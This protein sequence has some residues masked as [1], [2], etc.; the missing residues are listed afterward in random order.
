MIRKTITIVLTVAAGLTLVL[1]GASYWVSTSWMASGHPDYLDGCLST[2]LFDGAFSIRYTHGADP[3][4]VGQ[5]FDWGY[6]GLGLRSRTSTQMW[7]GATLRTSALELPF[8]LA[9]LLLG[10]YPIAALIR[11]P[12]RRWRRGKR[13]HCP[14]CG[15]DLTGNVTGICSECGTTLDP[16]DIPTVTPAARA[17][18]HLPRPLCR[19]GFVRKCILTG[20]SSVAIATL[21]FGL[22]SYWIS[23]A[24]SANITGNTGAWMACAAFW[25]EGGDAQTFCG[26][27]TGRMGSTAVERELWKLSVPFWIP[28]LVFG[29]YPAVVLLRGLIRRQRARASEAPSN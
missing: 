13:G 8:W 20:T 1:G 3:S 28:L 26:D 25:F 14:Q 24:L 21:M 11:G 10:A 12:V 29:L 16:N 9:A 19:R 18:E 15:Y 6:Y 17:D 4:D 2:H 23:T 22:L 27:S 7:D 5:R